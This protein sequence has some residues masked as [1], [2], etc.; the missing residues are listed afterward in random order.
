[1]TGPAAES[2]SYDS[3]EVFNQPP[4]LQNYNLFSSDLALQEGVRREGAAWAEDELTRF[5]AKCGAARVLALGALAN[6]YPP[7]LHT[8]DRYGRR[9]DEVEFH[10]AWH[11]LM[12]LGAGA[13]LHSAPWAEP[14][15]GAR[16]SSPRDKSSL[17]LE[18]R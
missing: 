5:G 7:T 9:R 2:S 16:A 8:H 14:R 17:S 12:L 13:G 11:E 6:R 15:P 4:P 3:N 1:M 10:P 18:H